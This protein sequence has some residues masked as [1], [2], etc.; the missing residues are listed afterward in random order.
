MARHY[1]R[2]LIGHFIRRRQREQ[3]MCT[4][5]CCR[6]Y[7]V[8]PGNYP[9]ILPNRLLRHASD[10]DLAGHYDKVVK[11]D[12]PRARRAEAQIIYEMERRDRAEAGR[13]QHRKAVAA[14]RAARQLER[15]AETERV[16]LEAEAYTRGNWVNAKGRAR[17]ISDREILTGREE[18]FQR[19]ASEEA[20]EYFRRHPRPTGAY[21]RGQDTRIAY[22]DPGRARRHPRRRAAPA[23]RW[24]RRDMRKPA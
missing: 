19:Y 7:R 22:S 17:G 1:R 20:R 5:A 8:H 16:Y 24:T 9:V 10:E 21:F 11:Q 3:Q 15:E 2:D 13:R 6:G 12:S 4:H 23:R 18:V 14:G